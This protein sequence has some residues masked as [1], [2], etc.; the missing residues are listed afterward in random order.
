MLAN[1][2]NAAEVGGFVLFVILTLI[3]RWP[4]MIEGGWSKERWALIALVIALV[5]WGS[6]KFLDVANEGSANRQTPAEATQEPKAEKN[7]LTASPLTKEE[8]GRPPKDTVKRQT[9]RNQTVVLDDKTFI[10]CDFT[11]VTFEYNGGG[12]VSFI[13]N[14]FSGER[15]L[16]SKKI[17]IN[18]MLWIMDNLEISR[19]VDLEKM[20][21][22]FKF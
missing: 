2:A 7:E 11:N 16:R 6:S 10:E 1:L 4:K 5:G 3:D 21:K 8:W 9:F 17:N 20:D 19:M 22:P 15:V 18:T 14:K 13:G 12:P